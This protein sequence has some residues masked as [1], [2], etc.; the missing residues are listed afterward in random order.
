MTGLHQHLFDLFRAIFGQEDLALFFVVIKGRLI[1]DHL[2]HDAVDDSI[3]VGPVFGGARNDQRRAGL[4]D[5][6]RVDLVDDGEVV[7]ALDHLVGRIDQIV[8]QIVEAELVVGAIGDVAAIGALTIALAQAVDD[9][10]DGHAQE[11]IDLTHPLAVALG[12]IVI[13]G[14]D[15]HALTAQR[16]EIGGGDSNQGLAFTGAHLRDAAL[17]QDHAAD[18][19]YIILALAEGPLGGFPHHGKGFVE[20]IVERF[21]LFDPRFE[22]SGLATKLLIRE[23]RELWLQGIDGQGSG[24]EGLNLAVVGRAEELFSEAEHELVRWSRGKRTAGAAA[25]LYYNAKARVRPDRLS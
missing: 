10:A 12:Q 20:Q 11:P 7:A 23:G 4:I 2:F 24:G 3:E 16:V 25:R 13:D 17:V 21:A 18:Q 8:A 14:D 1:D 5:Q 19:L 9:N 6:D 15:V 22:L